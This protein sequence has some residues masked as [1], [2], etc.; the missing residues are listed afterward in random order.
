MW[1][2]VTTKRGIPLGERFSKNP[3]PWDINLWAE[4]A[5]MKYIISIGKFSGEF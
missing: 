3:V 1:I 2:F 4:P 5:V